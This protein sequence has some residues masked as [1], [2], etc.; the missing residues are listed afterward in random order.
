MWWNVAALSGSK[1]F[2]TPNHSASSSCGQIAKHSTPFYKNCKVSSHSVKW[3]KMSPYFFLIAPK[4]EKPSGSS[5]NLS[6][7]VSTSSV[8]ITTSFFSV[9][10]SM[11][12]WHV[13]V[14]ALIVPSIYTHHVSPCHRPL[15]S[16]WA[17]RFTSHPHH[18]YSPSFRPWHK[19]PPVQRVST[20]RHLLP[21]AHDCS[22]AR[23]RNRHHATRR[24]WRQGPA[25]PRWQGSTPATRCGRPFSVGK[26]QWQPP[27]LVPR[28]GRL[29]PRWLS[30]FEPT[31]VFRGEDARSCQPNNCWSKNNDVPVGETWR[32]SPLGREKAFQLSLKLTLVVN[33]HP[34]LPSPKVARLSI[35]S[36]TLS[37]SS[38]TAWLALLQSWCLAPKK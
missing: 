14:Q 20:S 32:A 3:Y 38:F 34:C 9:A 15:A 5:W 25:G 17:P 8:T 21:E 28:K 29:E 12:A 35:S 18:L 33:F 4:T 26:K 7:I 2:Q 10:A 27:K 6:L 1:H 30:C 13:G 19:L 23:C 11:S 36:V 16:P 37:F 22:A 31:F 24:R